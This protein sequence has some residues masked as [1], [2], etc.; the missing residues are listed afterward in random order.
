MKQIFRHTYRSK[1]LVA[2]SCMAA[3]GMAYAQPSTA[4]A[5]DQLHDLP[6]LGS[7]AQAMPDASPSEATAPAASSQV[8]NPL[9]KAK[10]LARQAGERANG[11]LTNYRAEASMHGNSADS[12][13]V[14]NEN[15]SWTFTFVGGP[16]GATTPTVET[17][18]T[19]FANDWRTVVD[20]NGPIRDRPTRSPGTP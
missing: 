8:L 7:I 13:F 20:Y 12:P 6:R 9:N 19:V 2:L 10:N 15:G 5:R 4:S 18:V 16:P 11:G 1:W 14:D 17:V 3:G